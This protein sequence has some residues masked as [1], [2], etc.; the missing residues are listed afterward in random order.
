VIDLWQDFTQFMRQSAGSLADL[1]MVK[2]AAAIA[3]TAT[4][5]DI[6]KVQA[7]FIIL[8]FVDLFC[9]WVALSHKCLADEGSKDKGELWAI[10][11]NIRHAREK[12][13]IRSDPMRVHFCGK[14]WTYLLALL[15]AFGL[16][17]IFGGKNSFLL[18]ITAYL[19]FAEAISVMENLAE[20]EVKPAALIVN[21]IRGKIG[22]IR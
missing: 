12:G 20:A 19:A 14:L 5:A 11:R 7:G 18:A 1:A 3:I 2:A 16:D 8:I 22:G 6:F 15:T 9:K 17:L 10:I 4:G 21:F 13:Y